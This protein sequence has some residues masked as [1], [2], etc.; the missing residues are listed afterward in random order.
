MKKILLIGLAAAVAAVGCD[1]IG[2]GGKDAAAGD[3]TSV[4][5]EQ[6]RGDEPAKEQPDVV[7][8]WTLNN[9]RMGPDSTR[10]QINFDADGNGYYRIGSK[11][12]DFKWIGKDDKIYL[13]TEGSSTHVYNILAHDAKSLVIQEEGSD[14]NR[15]NHFVR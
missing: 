15:I 2:K 10:N 4:K 12:L 6:A 14:D 9:D 1:R 8:L 3:S 7:G 13:T 5:T 11:K